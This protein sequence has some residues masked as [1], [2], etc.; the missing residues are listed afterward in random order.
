MTVDEIAAAV[1]EEGDGGAQRALKELARDNASAPLL[2][3]QLAAYPDVDVRAWV[4]GTVRSMLPAAEA[5]PILLRLIRDRDAD[6]R[7]TAIS[8]LIAVDRTAAAAALV[9]MLRSRLRT[10]HEYPLFAAF[11]LADLRDHESLPAIRALADTAARPYV[12]RYASIAALLLEGRE[13][14][15][16]RRLRACEQGS[17]YSLAVAALIIGTPEARAT[18]DECMTNAPDEECRR[19]CQRALANRRPM[20]IHTR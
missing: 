13:D 9:P 3:A 1:M 7:D 8:D 5:V 16:L 17:T 20:Q 15:I 4:S 18:V 6:V 10:D 12:R 11:H 14:E 19:E 2:L